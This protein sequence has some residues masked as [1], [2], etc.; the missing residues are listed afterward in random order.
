MAIDKYIYITLKPDYFENLFK[1]RYSDIEIVDNPSK[2][3]H[4]RAREAL[5]MHN[6]SNGLEI[7]SCADLSA[8]SGLGSS[9]TFLVGLLKA[10]REYKRIDSSPDTIANEACH[11][12]IDRLKEPVG[13]QDQYISAFGGIKI[14]QIDKTGKV[15]T[16]NLKINKSSF[17]TFLN[18]IHVYSINVQ[19]SASS[20]LK[21]QQKLINNTEEILNTIKDYGY[22]TIDLLEN[23]KYDEY[24]LLLDSYWSYKKQLSDKISLS[25]VDEVYDEVKKNFNVLGGKIIGA[26]G[27]GFLMLYVNKE[28][29]KLEFFMKKLKMWKLNYKV[30]YTG[31]RVL[32]NYLENYT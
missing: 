26:G 12:E 9:G 17:N 31:S 5:M 10:L 7:N 23:E 3:I 15:N 1:L 30:D 21:D 32:G 6:V 2:L 29:E 8:N 22:K 18:N 28:H 25:F 24:G 16:S 4:T 11:I 20:I 27:G 13:K 19:R 14:F